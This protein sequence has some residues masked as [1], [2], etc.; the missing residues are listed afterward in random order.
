MSGPDETANLVA[1]ITEAFREHLAEETAKRPQTYQEA[2]SGSLPEQIDRYRQL[3]D[4]EMTVRSIAILQARGEWTEERARV[5]DPGKYPALTVAEH[6]EM[7][8]L[9]ERIAR[10]YRHPSHV[11]YA[12]RAGATW[13][14]IAAATG[15]TEHAA[16]AAYRDWAEGQHEYAGMSDDDYAAAIARAEG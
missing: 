8:A 12:V 3:A 9:G 7:I 6:L 2:A 13:E 4:R 14:Q 10:H 16:R 5:L 1:E 11:D 15:T